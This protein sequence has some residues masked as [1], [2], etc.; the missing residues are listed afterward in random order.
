MRALD[1]VQGIFTKLASIV[2]VRGRS[3]FACGECERWERC[4]LPPSDKCIV[5]AVQ[6]ARNGGRSSKWT[7]LHQW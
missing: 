6:I 1:V 3:D 5:M 7:I 2:T 4:G